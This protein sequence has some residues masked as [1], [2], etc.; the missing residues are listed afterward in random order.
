MLGNQLSQEDL[1]NN[2]QTIGYHADLSGDPQ[3]VAQ[4]LF[5][6]FLSQKKAISSSSTGKITKSG[7]DFQLINGRVVGQTILESQNQSQEAPKTVTVQTPVKTVT[8]NQPVVQSTSSSTSTSQSAGS[9]SGQPGDKWAAIDSKVTQLLQGQ[10][11]S[12]RVV[13]VK[14]GQSHSINVGNATSAVKNADENVVFPLASLQKV[15]TGAIFT[16]LVNE[17]H[18][19]LNQKEMLS[20]YFPKIPNADKITMRDLL[21]HVSGIDMDELT[22]TN[23]LS[24]DDAIQYTIDN[25]KSGQPEQKFDYT[26]ANY[27]IL[28]GILKK[29]TNQSYEQLVNTRIIQ[30]LGL[31]HTFFWDQ[32]PSNAVV[33]ESAHSDGKQDNQDPAFPSQSLLSSVVGAGNLYSTPEDYLKIQQ[34]LEDGQILIKD[35][36]N[37]LAY[38][39]HTSL[40]NNGYHGGLYHEDDNQK[41][42]RGTLSNTSY[43]NGM[44]MDEDNQNGVILFTN[45]HVKPEPTNTLKGLAEQIKEIVRATD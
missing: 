34:G 28:A 10:H 30:K 2:V 26:N 22:P 45:Q 21:D 15:I 6:A 38:S 1:K 8:V 27:T 25:L 40:G 4:R 41:W 11:I 39:G 18:S 29:I 5:N 31:K 36:Y 33:A 3:V 32:K 37:Y 35:D 16:Q 19:K 23:V 17:T 20:D 14:N 12:G 42:V 9:S 44:D 43:E 24:E 7:S 13:I